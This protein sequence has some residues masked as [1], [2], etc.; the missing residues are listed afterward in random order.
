MTSEPEKNARETSA[1]DSPQRREEGTWNSAPAP[2][3]AK[4]KGGFASMDRDAQ[5]LV[6]SSGGLAAQACGLAHRFT[7]EEARAAGKK[8]GAAI[9]RDRAHMA[10][11]GRRGGLA[12]RGYQHRQSGAQEA[13]KKTE[14]ATEKPKK[15]AKLEGERSSGSEALAHD[16]QRP[17]DIAQVVAGPQIEQPGLVEVTPPVKRRPSSRGHRKSAE[18]RRD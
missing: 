1:K 2:P 17:S 5:R 18:R 16:G 4:R 14:I 3:R 11:I 15:A 13:K 8:G 6:A 7:A 12:K 9:G 10:E